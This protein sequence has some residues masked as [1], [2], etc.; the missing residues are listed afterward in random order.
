MSLREALER[1]GTWKYHLERNGGCVIDFYRESLMEFLQPK[2]KRRPTRRPPPPPQV[3]KEGEP[4]TAKGGEPS[5]PAYLRRQEPAFLRPTG[6]R[7]PLLSGSSPD[8]VTI[9]GEMA[10]LYGS[11][12]SPDEII[13]KGETAPSSELVHQR[14]V[15]LE[16][17][18]CGPLPGLGA[19][20]A[21]IM[22]GGGTTCAEDWPYRGR[23]G[24]RRGQRGGR[25]ARAAR[26]AYPGAWRGA[27]AAGQGEHS[28]PWA[29]KTPPWR[30]KAGTAG[31]GEHSLPW[32]EK[33][34][35]WGWAARTRPWARAGPWAE[36]TPP[37]LFT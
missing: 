25:G 22:Y 37:W 27:G 10:P 3:P 7:A 5:E 2:M 8:E 14:I 16:S 20:P 26:R 21:V 24:G 36:T 33:T 28:S 4:T 30:W 32:A 17:L 9:Q 13:E 23:R 29:E 35:P 12:S 11:G 1:Q 19:C 18:D 34:P 15:H 31:Q 6:E